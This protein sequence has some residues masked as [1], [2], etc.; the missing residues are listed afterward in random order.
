VNRCDALNALGVAIALALAV[1]SVLVG[2]DH[3][4][5][6]PPE[7][8]AHPVMGDGAAVVDATGAQVPIAAYARV[9][10]LGLV[11][12]HLVLEWCDPARIVA[13]SAFSDG[14]DARRIGDAPR[15]EGLSQVEAVLALDPDLVLLAGGDAG[16]VARLRERGIAVFDL[17]PAHG[18]PSLRADLAA[19]GRLLGHADEA[20]R[21]AASLAHRLRPGAAAPD[22]ARP[23]RALVLHTYADQLFGGPN[24][25]VRRVG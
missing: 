4:A 1:G 25:C 7:A 10:S 23:L 12:D 2:A 16:S 19:L 14:R 22:G 13:Y 9:A 20:R 8:D 5:A 3:D 15:L 21:L 24:A 18:L 11:S 17:G 6:V